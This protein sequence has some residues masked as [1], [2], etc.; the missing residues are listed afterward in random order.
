[1]GVVLQGGP[2]FADT[3]VEVGLSPRPTAL[4]NMEA[5]RGEVF[6]GGFRAAAGIDRGEHLFT[7]GAD[8]A[9]AC[10]AGRSFGELSVG[11]QAGQ[12]GISPS[13]GFFTRL[14]WG[15]TTG[16]VV[17]ADSSDRRFTVGL[18]P[19]IP[20]SGPKQAPGL[21]TPLVPYL[22]VMPA[23]HFTVADRSLYEQAM[24]CWREGS[25]C[26]REARLLLMNAVGQGERWAH[27]GAEVRGRIPAP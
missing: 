15:G 22:S 6:N 2:Y 24:T 4:F 11:G 14:C 27:E 17:T 21:E 23:V 18:N 5:Q 10:E 1:M 19:R 8:A 12:G 25:Q 9:L 26:H 7:Y 3:S 20:L 13:G 16:L